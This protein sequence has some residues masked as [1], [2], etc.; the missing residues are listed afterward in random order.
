M[1]KGISI[2][3]SAITAMTLLSGVTWADEAASHWGYT[4]P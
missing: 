4:G 3:I 2:L 1:N